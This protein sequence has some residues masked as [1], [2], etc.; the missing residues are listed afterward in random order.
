VTTFARYLLFQLPSWIV[1]GVLLTWLRARF[2][3]SPWTAFGAW[4]AWA[5]KD[6]ML[7]PLVASAYEHEIATGAERLVGEIAVVCDALAPCGQ[8]RLRGELW[9]ACVD[10]GEHAPIGAR[11]RVIGG[12]GLTL[13]VRRESRG[14]RAPEL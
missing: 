6:L 9:R 2:E 13:S 3:L 11:V 5:V 10:E 1:V 7:Y 8:V 14:E 4:A 12:R